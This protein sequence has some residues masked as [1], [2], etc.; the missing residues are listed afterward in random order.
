[1]AVKNGCKKKKKKKKEHNSNL[2]SEVFL[3]AKNS[4]EQ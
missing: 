3:N 1:M 4:K 2:L